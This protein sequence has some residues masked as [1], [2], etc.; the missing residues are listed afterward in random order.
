MNELIINHTKADLNGAEVQMQWQSNIFGDISKI[1]GSHTY[2]IQL[3][4]TQTNNRIFMAAGIP[5]MQ[6]NSRIYLPCDYI[7]DGVKI[8]DDGNCTLVR[9]TPSS[10]E[11]AIVW[12]VVQGYEA[13][14]SDGYKLADLESSTGVVEYLMLSVS[15]T[16]RPISNGYF[17]AIYEDGWDSATGN[18]FPSSYPCVSAAYILGKIADYY[19]L[20][21]E[22]PTDT[23]TFIGKIIIPLVTQVRS[24]KNKSFA[25]EFDVQPYFDYD[26]E[27]GGTEKWCYTISNSANNLFTVVQIDSG[28]GVMNYIKAHGDATLTGHVYA[29]CGVSFYITIGA[30]DKL[31]TYNAVL[32]QDGT[33]IID[34]DITVSVKADETFSI[35]AS[36]NQK[37]QSS[38]RMDDISFAVDSDSD[39]RAGMNYPIMANLPDMTC[40][41]FI[42]EICVR[43]GVFPI[44]SGS[45]TTLRFIKADALL[46]NTPTEWELISRTNTE[47]SFSDYKQKNKLTY[48]TDDF[49]TDT[50]EG[51][52]VVE[53]ETLDASA[54]MFDSKFCAAKDFKLP[55]FKV[56]TD[57]DGKVTVI[58]NSLKPRIGITDDPDNPRFIFTGMDFASLIKANYTAYQSIIKSPTVIKAQIRIMPWQLAG[59]DFSTPIYIRTLGRCYGI[60]SIGSG[61]NNIYEVQLIQ[62]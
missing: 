8:I 2:T 5:T 28:K 38:F 22:W 11:V 40:I 20:T 50:A 33:Y 44:E 49:S 19:G 7:V 35:T 12:G 23:Q 51:S 10:Y 26:K 29:V 54:V 53:N 37:E 6:G 24:S 9:E 13:M 41:D 16:V 27:T 42:K 25:N 34:T 58:R 47:F 56:E 59:L 48:L 1:S 32:Q 62:L 4:H 39:L 30:D 18:N 60:I 21:F 3:P 61:K 43:A 31:T 46:N 15:P 55:L 17:Y 36:T 45:T 14:K 52:L 57:S